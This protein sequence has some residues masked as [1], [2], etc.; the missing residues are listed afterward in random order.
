M[1][2]SAQVE[3]SAQFDPALSQY[4]VE[5]SAR[6][7]RWRLYKT[8]RVPA[9]LLAALLICQLPFSRSNAADTLG[10]SNSLSLSGV[11]AFACPPLR[12]STPARAAVR[13][14]SLDRLRFTASN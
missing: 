8:V 9:F 13:T 4:L 6:E 1:D 7:R 14:A 11:A 12:Y 3:P 10:A 5:T 2:K